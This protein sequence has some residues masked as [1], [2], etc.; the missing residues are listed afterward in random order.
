M[1]ALWIPISIFAALMQAVRTA[2][3]RTLNQKMSTMGTTY[4]RSL[5]G[6][7]LM[8]LYLFFI[9]TYVDGAWPKLTLSFLLFV[10]GGALTQILAT[11]LLIQM[12]RLRNFAVGTMLTKTDIIMTA[13]IGSLI[14]SESLTGGGWWA[15]AVVLAGV[16][17][18]LIGKL[19][20]G[21]FRLSGQ[22]SV[23]G[24][25]SKSMRVA[26]VCAFMFTLSYLLYREA[27]LNLG[28]AGAVWRGAWTVVIATSM[29]VIGLGIWLLWKEAAVFTQLWPNRGIA[30]FIGVSSAL[31]SVGWFTAFAMEN[32]SYVRAVGQ[33]EAVFTLAIS[34]L[35]FKEKI[36]KLEFTGIIITV[37]GVL[38]FRLL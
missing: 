4:V 29:Q 5:F 16:F 2:G 34:W 36:T 26:V 31:G 20:I 27:T 8:M 10:A 14:F 23:G 33:I 3:Q 38:L 13:I 21:I 37:L 18:M 11:A 28:D 6:L 30:C 9:M 32:A 17:L 12:F 15:L 35:Y 25:F 19:G 22:S 7:P 24:L 1:D